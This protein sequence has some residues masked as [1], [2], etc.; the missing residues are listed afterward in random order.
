[1][2]FMNNVAEFDSHH[3]VLMLDEFQSIA[4]LREDRASLSDVSTYLRSLSQHSEGFSLII[5]GGG[6]LTHLIRVAEAASLFNIS[7]Q[8]SLGCLAAKDARQL[9]VN[10][11]R[12][13]VTYKPEVIKQLLHETDAHPFFLQLLL[14]QLTGQAVAAGQ[15]S[16]TVSDLDE[17]LRDWVPRQDE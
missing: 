2:D 17:V 8:L 4:T 1:S 7:H 5:S 15:T 13:W 11:V 6:I 14:E 16:L 10:P 9:I 12:S 3:L